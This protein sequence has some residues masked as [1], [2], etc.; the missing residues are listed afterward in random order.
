MTGTFQDLSV[1]HEEFFRGTW[2]SPDLIT[3]CSMEWAIFLSPG[4]HNIVQFL[5]CASPPLLRC[6]LC[7]NGIPCSLF[8]FFL[9]MYFTNKKKYQQNNRA[10]CMGRSSSEGEGWS[11]ME[12]EWDSAIWETG[13]RTNQYSPGHPKKHPGCHRYGTHRTASHIPQK[14]V[15]SSKISLCFLHYLPNPVLLSI[16][17]WPRYSEHLHHYYMYMFEW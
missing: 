1:T 14:Y 6:C 8:V 10:Y 11:T 5:P 2:L 4:L 12:I 16:Q 9:S 13:A 7:S 17:C 3:L 15:L